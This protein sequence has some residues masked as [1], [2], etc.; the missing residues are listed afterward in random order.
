[1]KKKAPQPTHIAYAFHKYFDTMVFLVWGGAGV[2]L[3][4]YNLV[5]F[6]SEYLFPE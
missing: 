2:N 4:I 1:M 6:Y 5:V 3:P